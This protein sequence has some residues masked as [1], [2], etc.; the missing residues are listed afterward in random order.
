MGREQGE[1]G[2]LGSTEEQV[3]FQV[4]GRN[5]VEESEMNTAGRKA[6]AIVQMIS[7]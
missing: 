3:T 1:D 6:E 4:E 2:G 5:R 7:C